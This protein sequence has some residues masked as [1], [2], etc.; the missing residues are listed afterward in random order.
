M[1]AIMSDIH[2][3]LEAIQ[4]VLADLDRQGVSSVYNLGDTT[5]YGPNPLECIDLAL[6]MHIVLMGN[7]DQAALFNV[8]GF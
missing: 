6:E 3:N 1:Q 2:G 5:G 8:D 7:N 4:A